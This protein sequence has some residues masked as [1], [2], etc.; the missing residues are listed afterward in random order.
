VDGDILLCQEPHLHWGAQECGGGASPS[1]V[2]RGQSRLATKEAKCGDGDGG[3]TRDSGGR[4]D[5]QGTE[6]HREYL[7]QG[8]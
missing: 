5:E 6:A 2:G 4:G 7:Q 8:P 3:V 1:L